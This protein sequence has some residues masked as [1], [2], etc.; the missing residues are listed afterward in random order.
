MCSRF[1]FALLFSGV[2]AVISPAQ[3]TDVVVQGASM[4]DGWGLAYVRG[5]RAGLSAS[6]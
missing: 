4:N 3:Q 6:E 1:A 5:G 2:L